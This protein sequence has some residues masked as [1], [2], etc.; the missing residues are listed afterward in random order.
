M[1]NTDFWNI[2]Y[3]K[4]IS[5]SSIRFYWQQQNVCSCF[6]IRI[7][8]FVFTIS[9][10]EFRV[11]SFEFRVS[12]FE[13]RV[14]SFAIYVFIFCFISHVFFFIVLVSAYCKIPPSC[15]AKNSPWTLQDEFIICRPNFGTT[16]Y[17]G[18]EGI[19]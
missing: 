3:L 19:F 16:Y 8:F 9:S 11:S 1:S 14:S 2:F 10:F 17:Q 6:V 15:E 5:I 18:R 13:F 12:S 7:W 4:D